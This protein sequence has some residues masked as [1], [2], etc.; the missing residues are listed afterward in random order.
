MKMK[1]LI[2][3]G[4]NLNLLGIWSANRNKTITLDK[5]NRHIRKYIRDKKIDLKIIQTNEEAKAI[6]YIQ[7]NR[8]KIDAIIT[9]PGIWQ[10]N[11]YGLAEVLELTNIPFITITYKE[12]DY[13]KLLNGK[14]NITDEDLYN[15]MSTAINE[16]T[17]EYEK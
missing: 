17:N 6:S 8:K 15:A 16:I 1:I 4:P 3:Y 10:Y 13:I 14:N 7:N 2:L 12:K 11:A 5:L 9:V